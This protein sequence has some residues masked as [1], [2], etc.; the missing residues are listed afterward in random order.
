MNHPFVLLIGAILSIGI[1]WNTLIVG[2]QKY[3]GQL[4]SDDGLPQVLNGMQKQG[5][6]V[7]VSSGCVK[8]HT[9]QVRF[10]ENDAKYAPRFSTANDFVGQEM[11]LLGTHRIGPDLSNLG[12]NARYTG[13]DGLENLYRTLFHAKESPVLAES[14]LAGL[15]PRHTFLFDKVKLDELSPDTEFASLAAD[16]GK[17]AGLEDGY[18][19]VPT[20]KAEALSRYLLG[21]KLDQ[22]LFVSPIPDPE[23]EK[24]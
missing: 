9:Q 1:S 3:F 17:Q 24:N 13:D 2:P 21:L 20:Y 22:S 4:G 19:Y 15:M 10:F 16:L 23:E 8:C 12:N 7:F 11:P 6:Q 18:G 14:K 5:R